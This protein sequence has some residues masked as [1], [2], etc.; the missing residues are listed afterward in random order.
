VKVETFALERWMSTWEVKVDYD[1]AESGIYPMT[2]NELLDLLPTAERDQT[3]AR[4]LDLRL[5]YT[6]ARGTQQ[7]RETIAATYADVSPDEVLVTTGAIEAN[8]L[9]FNSLLDAG[10]R[11]VAVYPAYQQLYAVAKAIGCDVA[12]WKL[13]EEDGFRFDLGELE[14]LVTPE[15][16]LIV[17]NTPHNPTGAILSAADLERISRLAESVGAYVLADE[18]YRWLDLPGGEPLAPPMRDL[19]TTAISVGTFS[20]P[21]GLPGLRIGWIAAT[22][23]IVRRCWGT[24]DY[25]SLAPARLSDALA[26]V[27]LRLR[28]R[29]VVRNHEIVAANLA[30]AD[31]WFAEQ[32][33]LVSWTRPRAGLLALM[34]YNLDMPSLDLSNKLAAEYSV[35]LAPGSAFGFEGH[36]RLGI[37]QTPRIFEEGLSRTGACLARLRREGVAER[38]VAV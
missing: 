27:A 2:V 31:A 34:R 5:G 15:T 24:R 38:A 14:R 25:I 7:L 17:A 11:V 9:L 10:D 20:K 21:F 37:G 22:E 12:L 26:D 28:D 3:L 35:M 36:L 13:N 32:A 1:I 8:Y 16:K 30:T 29:I 19:G 23:E 6:E 33:D 4:L 18:A